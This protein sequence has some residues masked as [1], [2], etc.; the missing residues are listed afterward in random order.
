MRTKNDLQ[1]HSQCRRIMFCKEPARQQKVR[2]VTLCDTFLALVWFYACSIGACSSETS[3]VVKWHH[4]PMFFA[5]SRCLDSRFVHRLS[6]RNFSFFCALPSSPL[7]SPSCKRHRKHPLLWL[8]WHA[9]QVKVK[10]M[11]IFSLVLSTQSTNEKQEFYTETF[12]T[13]ARWWIS[14][15][16]DKLCDKF[17]CFLKKSVWRFPFCCRAF[18]DMR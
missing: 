9:W 2:C 5:L 17:C 7:L 6:H 11:L 10:K 3:F 14:G 1:L 15:W 12:S 16:N 18:I 4:W 13:I 8:M